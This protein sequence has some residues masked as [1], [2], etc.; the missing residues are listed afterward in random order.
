MSS[1]ICI[2]DNEEV[3]IFS[4][5][6]LILNFLL[7]EKKKFITTVNLRFKKGQHKGKRG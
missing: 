6:S 2:D 3:Q 1:T 7:I 4:S 5:E